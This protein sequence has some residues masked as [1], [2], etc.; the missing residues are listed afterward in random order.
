[1]VDAG[2]C[3]AH[4]ADLLPARRVELGMVC[5]AAD[6]LDR[7]HALLLSVLTVLGQRRARPLLG[8][9]AQGCRRGGSTRRAPGASRATEAAGAPPRR[10]CAG[11]EPIEPVGAKRCRGD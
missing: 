2:D 9:L 5:E 3:E 10:P 4:P 7:V 1:A 8:G 6:Q 11:W